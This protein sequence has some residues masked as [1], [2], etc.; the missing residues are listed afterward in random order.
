MG[1]GAQRHGRDDVTGEA[2]QAAEEEPREAVLSRL[3]AF[4]QRAPPVLRHFEDAGRLFNVDAGKPVAEVTRD[5][6][7]MVHRARHLL[8]LD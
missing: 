4:A 8:D 5:V 2:L 7:V 1:T 6:E 3:T